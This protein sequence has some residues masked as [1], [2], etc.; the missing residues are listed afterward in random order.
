MK[1]SANRHFKPVVEFNNA[2]DVSFQSLSVKKRTSLYINCLPLFY[3]LPSISFVVHIL[4]LFPPL[5]IMTVYYLEASDIF[6]L[7]PI[8]N[9]HFVQGQKQIGVLEMCSHADS[10]IRLYQTI[11]L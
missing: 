1:H 8:C 11:L 6:F 9:S 7:V 3:Y 5:L 10:T 4:N 2:T